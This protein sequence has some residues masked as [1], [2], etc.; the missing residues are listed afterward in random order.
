MPLA[1]MASKSLVMASGEVST[2]SH[3]QKTHGRADGGGW[4]KPWSKLTI[5]PALA[6]TSSAKPAS[7]QATW[8]ILVFFI[9]L[10]CE[11]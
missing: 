10:G 7:Q 11:I 1:C 2:R 9:S 4:M 6:L 3:I 5:S 8:L